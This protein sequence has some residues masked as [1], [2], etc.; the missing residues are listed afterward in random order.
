MRTFY[1]AVACFAGLLC[2]VAASAQPKPSPSTSG[3]KEKIEALYQA[4]AKAFKAK[5]VN[6]IM[7]FYDPK[8]LFV[9]DLV[10]PREYPNW[11][12]YK[13]DWE[14]TFAAMP[15]PLDTTLSE[16]AIT[17]EGPVAYAHSIQTG[18]FT[19]KDGTRIDLAVRVTDVWHKVNGKWL[20]VQEHVSVP[21]DLATGKPDMMSK[22]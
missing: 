12:A 4:Y 17:V 10:P 5:D 16:L 11:D 18:Y 2:A 3:D 20:I 7:A 21:V 9:F 14:E 6:A 1:L 22:P 15:G 13:K 19:G 8:E